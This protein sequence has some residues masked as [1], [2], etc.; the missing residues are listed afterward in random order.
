ML[1]LYL[2]RHPKTQGQQD[3]IKGHEDIGLEDGWEQGV[4]ELA[5]RLHRT[6]PIDAVMASDLQRARFPAL[7]IAGYLE[8]AQQR[9]IDLF[10]SELLRE[11]NAGCY[12]RKRFHQ[13]DANGKN[14]HDY[15]FEMNEITGGESRAQVYERI[16]LVKTRYL[17]KYQGNGRIIIVNHGWLINHWRNHELGDDS[18]PYNRMPNLG[19]LCLVLDG[20]SAREI[21]FR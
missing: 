12:A 18:I 6:G 14:P 2:L 15:I 10:V 13:I 16:D 3:I 1:T 17:D 20:Q 4:D 21:P 19:V 8:Q 11:R 5:E 7:R 9:K